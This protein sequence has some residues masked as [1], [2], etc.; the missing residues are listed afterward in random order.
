MRRIACQERDDWKQTATE[1]GFVFAAPNGERYWD[2]RAYY[3][4]SLDEIER[5]IETPTGEIEAM[6]RE[7]VDRVAASEQ[8]LQRLR[9]P[10]LCWDLVAASWKRRDSSLYGRMDLCYDGTAPAKLLEY[11]ADT[12]T[13]LFEAAVF[14]WIWLEHCSA[15]G[16][17][18]HGADQYNSIH[19]R[20]IARW[21]EIGEGRPLHLAGLLTDDEDAGTLS[22]LEDV[23]RQGGLSTSRIE[24]SD[25][26]WLRKKF[27]DLANR[28]IELA[29]KLYPW[30][31]MAREAFARNLVNAAT[32]WVEPPWRMVLSNKG[33]LPLLWEMFPNHPN[34][35]AAYFDDDPQAAR[36]GRAYVRKP[37]YSRE[38]A[39]IEIVR[40]SATPLVHAGPYGAEGHI[41]QAYAPLPDFDGG[42]PVLGS[43][44][45]GGVPCGLSIREDDTPVTGNLSRFLPHAI[46]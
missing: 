32:R 19:E 25:I 33:I 7:L 35:L 36:L 14:Q 13:S 26:G 42:Y 15:R 44:L 4:F 16:I 11:N 31:W 38:G 1:T 17:I 8:L 22:Y 12:P 2:E 29:F 9:I 30:E 27:V 41:R 20:L 28:P 37:L 18:P 43:W 3:A 5:D 46:L 34:L 21:R 10:Q 45:V 24:M 39:N 40:G 23:A 6:C